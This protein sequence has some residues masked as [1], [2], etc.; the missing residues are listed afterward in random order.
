MQR[1]AGLLAAAA[2]M[3]GLWVLLAPEFFSDE[4]T[5]TELREGRDGLLSAIMPLV[6]LPFVISMILGAV[7]GT[8]SYLFRRHS[9][10]T[11]AWLLA[12]VPIVIVLWPLSAFVVAASHLSF[13]FAAD[14]PELRI[15]HVSGISVDGSYAATLKGLVPLQRNA[16]L[17]E[18]YLA[19]GGSIWKL[20]AYADGDHLQPIKAEPSQIFTSENEPLSDI[21]KRDSKLFIIAGRDLLLADLSGETVAR[22]A[23]LPFAGMQLGQRKRSFGAA[24]ELLV[25]GNDGDQ[26]FV[27]ELKPNGSY[28]KLM[29]GEGQIAGAA[30][31]HDRILVAFETRVLALQPGHNPTVEFQVPGSDK[32]TS[33]LVRQTTIDSTDQCTLLVATANAI[34]AVQGGLATMLILGLGGQ[35]SADENQDA[36]FQ[37][38]D[39]PRNSIIG[40]SFEESMTA[41]ADGNGSQ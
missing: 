39:A 28:A 10:W 38:I 18:T 25:F 19:N 26:S 22:L 13:G 7:A 11:E 23:S 24:S 27:Y 20:S 17:S 36:G 37:V 32:I 1:I 21:L 30:G 35:L 34:Y 2:L 33:I 3:M 40:I 15:A 12:S 9:S 14:Q 6:F 8:A 4:R 31:C 5:L 16:R 41:E 29:D